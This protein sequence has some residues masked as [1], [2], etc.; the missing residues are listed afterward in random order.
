[1]IFGRSL[2]ELIFMIPVIIIALSCHEYAHA[3]A[4]CSL[5][6]QTARY[7]GRMTLN[8]K[9]HL[10]P[11]GALAL[12]FFGFGW[13]KPV[14]VN[15]HNLKMKNKYLGMTLVSLAGPLMNFLLAGAATLLVISLNSLLSPYFDIWS[16]SAV[17]LIIN[18]FIFFTLFA[19]INI[20]LGIFNLIPVPPLDGSKILL[21]LLPY[22]L[23]SKLYQYERYGF[24]ILIIL[25]FSG[26]LGR[27]ISPVINWYLMNIITITGRWE[28]FLF[29]AS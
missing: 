23:A 17:S 11:I 19:Y 13:A 14:P 8:P 18:G 1:M 16:E 15:M 6:D 24:I 9:N 4:A 22:N 3:R 27:L 29:F 20:V 5:G 28:I 26:V 25:M 2:Q 7:M 12:L 21:G 10:D